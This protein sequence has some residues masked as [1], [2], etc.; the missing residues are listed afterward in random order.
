[1][2]AHGAFH[3][4]LKGADFITTTYLNDLNDADLLVRPVPNANHIAWQLGHLIVAEN[5]MLSEVCP[6]AMPALP[7]GFREKHTKETAGS[8]DPAAFLS[9][10]EYL[11]L[12]REQRAATLKALDSLSEADL[13]RP[14]PESMKSFVATVGG[15]FNTQALHWLMHA[16]QWVIVRRKLGHK[17]I[18]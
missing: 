7:A 4:A 11:R 5:G 8:D 13:D 14:A 1:M 6:G 18:F 12:Y 10:D 16:G 15:I 2:N 9:K 3:D 17:P